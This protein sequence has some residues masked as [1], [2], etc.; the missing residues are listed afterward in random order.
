[1]LDED[2][3]IN[4]FC[5]VIQVHFNNWEIIFSSCSIS[6][7]IC[8]AANEKT[9]PPKKRENPTINETD[10][11]LIPANTIFTCW[12]S[13]YTKKKDVVKTSGLIMLIK[14][15]LVCVIFLNSHVSFFFT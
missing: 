13:T 7:G 2:V 8:I 5:T 15:Y 12:Y 4:V 9:P 10:T 3:A 14:I 11:M 6:T 1:M